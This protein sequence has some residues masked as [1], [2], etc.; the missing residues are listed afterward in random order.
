MLVIDDCDGLGCNPSCPS[1][2]L[3]PASRDESDGA[4]VWTVVLSTLACAALVLGA[5]V[6]VCVRVGVVSH[7]SLSI[8]VVQH[9][10]W[11]PTVTKQGTPNAAEE[12]YK[13]LWYIRTPTRTVVD[14]LGPP[15]W[16]FVELYCSL[17]QKSRRKNWGMY[18]PL[19]K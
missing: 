2:L 14:Y 9:I 1:E 10:P 17:V 11:G 7:M 4:V 15:V 16:S 19:R 5:G 3:L 18:V 6:C 8:I 13:K 12:T